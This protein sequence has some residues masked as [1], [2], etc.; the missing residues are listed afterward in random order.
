MHSLSHPRPG[1]DRSHVK[2]IKNRS[3]L[4]S[5]LFKAFL[6][7]CVFVQM[8]VWVCVL[9]VYRFM[10][11]VVAVVATGWV[12]DL[13]LRSF[14]LD[15]VGVSVSGSEGPRDVGG[16]AGWTLK[17]YSKF[18]LK[19]TTSTIYQ[20]FGKTVHMS[21]F[22]A[23]LVLWDMMVAVTLWVTYQFV[24]EER[25]VGNWVTPAANNGKMWRREEES[26]ITHLKLLL[27][28]ML[29]V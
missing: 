23:L 27:K 10:W 13:V 2:S 21:F 28:D 12:N 11:T 26:K 5:C 16:R 18:T 17:I 14:E 25:A 3:C 19:Q 9:H 22:A 8:H 15:R 24:K 4:H 7:N 1:V 6:R 29:S 20:T